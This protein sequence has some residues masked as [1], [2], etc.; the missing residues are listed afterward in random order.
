MQKQLYNSLFLILLTGCS[1]FY[2]K[3]APLKLCS[4]NPHFA[5]FRGKSEILLGSTEHY[6]A[7]LNLGFNYIKYLDQLKKE[8]FNLT[9]TWTGI[10]RE[11]STSFGITNNTMAPK[12]ND[13]ICPWVRSKTPG[14]FAGGNKFDL[15]QWDINYFNRLH[16]FVKEASKKAIVVEISLF[17]FFHSP[18]TWNLCPLNPINNINP[19]KPISRQE[20]WSL[21]DAGF[22]K[23]QEAYIRKVV[24]ELNSFDNVFFEIINEPYS[25]AAFNS[26]DVKEDWQE[27]V[28]KIICD[29]EKNLKYKHLIQQNIRPDAKPYSDMNSRISILSFHYAMGENA[30]ANYHLNKLLSDGETGFDGP[31]ELPYREE[32]WHFILSGGGMFDHLDYSFIAGYEDGTYKMPLNSPGWGGKKLRDQFITLK[33]IIYKLDFV[34]MKPDSGLLLYNK[35]RQL[36]CSVF[37]K[38]DSVY[39]G[40]FS[41]NS[42]NYSLLFNGSITSKY[43]EKYTFYTASDVGV[44]VW[45]ND[46]LLINNWTS[47]VVVVDSADIELKARQ[48]NTIKIEYFNGLNDATLNLLWKCK[49][50]SKEIVPASAFSVLNQSGLK[51]TY[52]EDTNLKNISDSGYCRQV[53][54]DGDIYALLGKNKKPEPM[55]TILNLDGGKYSI[56]WLNPEDGKQLNQ[57]FIEVKT[58]KTIVH[59]PPFLNDILLKIT[60]K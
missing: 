53:K 57:E 2:H 23:I 13:Y 33:N 44:R 41:R 42:Y 14:Y 18:T 22:L 35:P 32:A 48:K 56:T 21:K 47:H 4:Q 24:S 6:G 12:P 34:N 43:S 10:Y 49:D 52:Y 26:I 9:R 46:K 28:S 45:I 60:K 36:T 30:K 54:F 7:V 8:G 20:A 27:W 38:K 59:S 16:D 51:V 50:L 37:A 55:S 25:G 3:D 15:T 40:Y 39:L 19:L 11:D 5:E 1:N 29:T 17:C 58:Q 31:Y